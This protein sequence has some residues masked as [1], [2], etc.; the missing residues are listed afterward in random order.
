M[1]LPKTNPKIGGQR[2]S[3]V[4]GSRVME[5]N[6]DP[7]T[8]FRLS[9]LPEGFDRIERLHCKHPGALANL[10]LKRYAELLQQSP[11]RGRPKQFSISHPSAAYISSRS[12]SP[13]RLQAYL[14]PEIQGEMKT[15][16]TTLPT[17]KTTTR[18]AWVGVPRGEARA[19]KLEQAEAPILTPN[20][21]QD[22]LDF[23][24]I[25]NRSRDLP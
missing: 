21:Q 10:T 19:R 13:G 1:L 20:D 8:D 17:T 11:G 9:S 23:A 6:K 14:G 3:D 24:L 25:R 15:L 7:D 4:D 22:K 12:I 18:G 2:A 16:H 5:D